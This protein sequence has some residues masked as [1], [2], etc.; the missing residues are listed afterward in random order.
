MRQIAGQVVFELRRPPQPDSGQV[1]NAKPRHEFVERR[2]PVG[3][4]HAIIVGVARFG[5]AEVP[6]V[7]PVP[8]PGQDLLVGQLP[9]A[10]GIRASQR[11][12]LCAVE[13]VMHFGP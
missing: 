7:H 12:E 9:A 2:S 3:E 13:P 5:A 6:L 8:Q 10:V 11:D 1:A 4:G